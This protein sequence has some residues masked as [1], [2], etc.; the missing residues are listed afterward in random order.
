MQILGVH[1]NPDILGSPK[2]LSSEVMS[3]DLLSV[4]KEQY[5]VLRMVATAKGGFLLP[6]CGGLF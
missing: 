4:G 1:E 3:S 5:C 2:A 6:L